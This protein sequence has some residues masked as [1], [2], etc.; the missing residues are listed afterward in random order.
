MRRGRALIAGLC[1]SIVV[2]GVDVGVAAA[3]IGDHPRRAVAASAVSAVVAPKLVPSAQVTAAAQAAPSPLAPAPPPQPTPPPAP[4]VA[5]IPSVAEKPARAGAWTLGPYEGLGVWIDVYDW[6]NELTGGHPRI[7][8]S[9][10]DHMADLGI[11]TIYI[12]TAHRRSATD[13][14]EP[15]R[16]QGIIDRAHVR[17]MDVVAWYLPMLDDLNVDL[18]RLVAASQLDVDGLGVD[19]E[20]L[21]VADPV[22]RT[23]RLLQLST[24][25]RQAMGR[26]AIAA[27]TPSAVHLQVVNPG[28]WPGFPWPELGATYDV[29]LP[30]SYWSVR[31]PE[32]HSGERYIGENID[33]I[34]AATGRPDMPIHVVGGIADG[35]SGDDLLGMVRAVQARGILG[36]SLYD[37]ATSQ[38]AQWDILRSLRVG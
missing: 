37:W 3:R 21:S 23:R 5:P 26:R 30:M 17:G 6:T 25:L 16:L 2:F 24:S 1:L 15:G 14:I 27:I 31:K 34:R 38:P 20:S 36:G 9:D 32:W 18:R 29:I 22:E 19:I 28:F 7:Q 4:A 35:V 8:L 33:R 10:I 11:Q 12:Q 13:V